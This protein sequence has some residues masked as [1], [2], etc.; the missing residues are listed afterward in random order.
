MKIFKKIGLGFLKYF[1]AFLASVVCVA[2]IMIAS[3]LLSKKSNEPVQQLPTGT[4]K[5]SA[6]EKIISNLEQMKN[7]E[8]DLNVEIA[9]PTMEPIVI[10]SII[11][12]NAENQ[13]EQ[14]QFQPVASVENSNSTAIKVELNVSIGNEIIDVNV[15]Y[16][17]DMLYADFAGTCVKFQEVFDAL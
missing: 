8:F 10:N 12:I 13:K 9:S 4:A 3:S 15:A 2:S 6:V 11:E 17:N 16:L 7:G 5:E 1:G 14:T